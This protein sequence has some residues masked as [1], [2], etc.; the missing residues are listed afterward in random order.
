MALTAIQSESI[1]S[2][3]AQKQQT[4]I[5]VRLTT[6]SI[7]YSIPNAKYL[8]PSDWKRFQLSQLINKVLQLDQPVPFDFVVNDQ[9]LR[10]SVKSFI[11]S[12]GLSTE[13]V[14]EIEY[15]ESVLP[16]KFIQSLEHDDWISDLSISKQGTF[17]TASYDSNLRLFSASDSTKPVLTISGHEQ[18]VLSVSWINS[19]TK[20]SSGPSR[21]ASGGLDRVVKIWEISSSETNLLQLEQSYSYKNTH[22]L[23]LH[24][25]PVSTI[26]SCEHDQSAGQLL[27]GD[28]EGVLALW[29]LSSSIGDRQTEPE[30]AEFPNEDPRNLKRRKKNQNLKS[31]G[32]SVISKQPVQV[33]SAHQ[34]KISRAIFS[35][36]DSNKVFTASHDHTVKRFDLETGLEE[37]SK[38][39]GP[40]KCLLDIDECQ[41]REGLLVTG[42]MD[43]TICFWD[44]RDGKV[45]IA[46]SGPQAY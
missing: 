32:S 25:S 39:A 2:T 35:K 22:V 33:V 27:T 42:C 9:L 18:P 20:D 13:S 1:T 24:K 21:I 36:S 7:R 23:P 16:P 12:R 3:T 4:M 28:W 40:E 38:L 6:K 26:Q 19:P 11:D 30:N 34:S 41:G 29:D 8:V 37:W 31:S 10:T 45:Q 46:Y 17:L 44:C 14:L 43:R 15:L 5:T